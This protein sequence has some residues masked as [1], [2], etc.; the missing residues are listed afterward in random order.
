[1]TL[2]KQQQKDKATK[3]FTKKV[4]LAEEVRYAI[5]DPAW[6]AYQAKIKKIDNQVE[7]EV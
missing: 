7:E 5:L 3:A 4:E 1:M 2:T 6:E